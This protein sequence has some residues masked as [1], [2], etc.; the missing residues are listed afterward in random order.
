MKNNLSRIPGC[1]IHVLSISLC[2]SHPYTSTTTYKWEFGVKHTSWIHTNT[3][4][5]QNSINKKIIFLKKS[6][7]AE[8]T[9]K[10]SVNKMDK[11]KSFISFCE[12]IHFIYYKKSQL[13]LIA[14]FFE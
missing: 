1:N 3:Q 13:K 4:V 11:I 2:L 8:G 5:G 12:K 7:F 6:R 10:L 9:N 14:D